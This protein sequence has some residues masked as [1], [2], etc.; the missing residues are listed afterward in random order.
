MRAAVAHGGGRISI[1][2]VP[3]PT[4]A[5]DD[6]VVRV[7]GCG[8]CGTDLHALGGE[9][10]IS[11]PRILGHEAW[12]EVVALGG[13]V[14]NVAIGDSVAI[15]PTLMCRTCDECLAGHTNLCVN[16]GV[17]GGTQDGAWAELVSI[18]QQNAHVLPPDYPHELASLIEPIAC[19]VHGLERLNPDPG[20]AA[21]VLGAGTM[22]LLMAVMLEHR[23]VGPVA[24]SDVNP[25]KLLN[26]REDFGLTTI[27]PDMVDDR[28]FR[29]VVEATGNPLGFEAAM[30]AVG[31]AGA[32]LVFGVASPTA[33][34]RVNP[35][36]VYA[37]ELRIVGSMAIL[38]SFAPALE[39]VVSL[40]SRLAPLITHRF[41][42]DR[43][44]DAVE[45][46]RAGAAIKVVL[47]PGTR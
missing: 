24:V 33:S 46:L 7:R 41:P 8:I 40:R 45:A 29:T 28:S 25:E 30:R 23:G 3:D 19:A 13:G 44:A 26:A 42:L 38:D 21:L 39:E 32:V 27:N 11:F 4:P 34:A 5:P 6:I 37:D 2:S 47:E 9:L 22:G 36:Q 16:R 1:E 15:D 18:P 17:I 10:G 12:G 35:H 31:P 20:N 14:H 43:A